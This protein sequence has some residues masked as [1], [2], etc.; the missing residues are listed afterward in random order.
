MATRLLLIDP[1][2]KF[3]VT[4][5]QALDG[6]GEFAVTVTANG[7][8]AL[9]AL[10][11]ERHDLVVMAF[12]TPDMDVLEILV[13]T[14]QVQ[15]RIPVIVTP[16][17]P[18]EQDRVRL[19][20]VQGAIQKPYS[21][22]NLIQYIRSVMAR[23]E[24][25]PTSPH[26]TPRP[27][28]AAP[29]RPQPTDEYSPPQMP[30]ALLH[31]LDDQ[32]KPPPPSPTEL[33]DRVEE[34]KLEPPP[35]PAPRY[36]D[37]DRLRTPAPAEILE[38][39]E[40]L[41]R[42]R[43]DELV[44]SWETPDAASEPEEDQAVED[45]GQTHR[46]TWEEPDATGE[47]GEE[48]E[49]A[50]TA[51]LFDWEEPDE[52]ATL[53][54]RGR[55]DEQP[56]VTREL[57][58]W[59][60]ADETGTLGERGQADEEQPVTR[61][62]YNWE[63]ADETA[64]LGE[65][66]TLNGE[67]APPGTTRALAWDEE[68]AETR[69]LSG[70]EARDDVMSAHGWEQKP[71]DTKPLGIREDEP[72]PR[73]DDTPTVPT[74]DLEGVR[75]FLAT[76]HHEQDPSVFGEV[77][78]AVAQAPPEP[79]ARS[80]DDRVFDDLV[81][82]MRGPDT[83]SPGRSTLEDLLASIATDTARG[84]SD[85]DL[86]PENTLD[87]VLD[88][89]RRGTSLSPA[90]D[91]TEDAL[92]ESE[93]DDATIGDVIGDLFDPAFEGVLAALAG[94]EIEDE[95]PEPSYTI[96][97]R[98]GRENLAPSEEDQIGFE[99]L[100]ADEDQP[101]WLE[102]YSGDEIEPA[103]PYRDERRE[104]AIQ[105]PPVTA[106]DSSS[107]PAT[108]ALSAVSSP[109][110]DDFSLND[111]LA[112]IEEQLPP[113]RTDRP[114]LKPLPSWERGR[115]SLEAKQLEAMFDHI[116][117]EEDESAAEGIAPPPHIAP[118]ED[119]PMPGL[120]TP[121]PIGKDSAEPTQPVRARRRD[122]EE[123][124]PPVAEDINGVPIQ[125]ADTVPIRVPVADV[126]DAAEAWDA[127][128][129]EL[130]E[131]EEALAAELD[132]LLD[133]ELA[134]AD[135]AEIAAI[136]EYEAGED[137][138]PAMLSVA[139]LMALADLPLDAESAEFDPLSEE[140]AAV[141]FDAYQA[142]RERAALLAGEDEAAVGDEF[143]LED[144]V[145]DEEYEAAEEVFMAGLR[146][147]LEADAEP[148]AVSEAEPE[149]E[150]AA[151]YEPDY[152]QAFEQAEEPAYEAAYEP[153]PEDAWD[154]AE[155]AEQQADEDFAIDERVI[156][157]D[158]HL[159]P[160][161]ADE[162]AWMLMGDEGEDYAAAEADDEAALARIAVE[163]TQY[164]LE[165]SAQATMLSRPGTLLAQAGDLPDSAMDRLFSTVD[166]A[167]RSSPPQTDSLIRYISL[168]DVGECL[169][170]SVLVEQDLA[171]SMIFNANTPVRAIRRQAR[172][173]SESLAFVPERTDEEPPAS[174][175][176]PSRPTDLRPPQ[177]LRTAVQVGQEGEEEVVEVEEAPRAD[178]PSIGYTCVWLPH[179]A[180]PGLND[181]LADELP[182]WLDAL[183]ANKVWNVHDVAVYEDYV[184]VSLE[185]PFKTL[186]DDVIVEM[187]DETTAR[188]AEQLPD[189]LS[190]S[191][192]LWSDGYYVV[193]PPRE[194]TEREIMSFVTYHTQS[195]VD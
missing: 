72:P 117:R 110:D 107:Y 58:D 74:H 183:A 163:L 78:D 34:E 121:P 142:E 147:S 86:P 49:P 113:A 102:S 119:L 8:A 83:S 88:A 126:D 129:D 12:N 179:S 95:I 20:D 61:E 181:D 145:T 84:M 192:L 52:T 30:A 143:D 21:A 15:H 105:E 184:T 11:R 100:S 33:L 153:E 98:G 36:E 185:V 5:K 166:N 152:A 55:V 140:W 164:S 54:E 159:I 174:K 76:D 31:L 42:S 9:D 85:D 82:S 59:E 44:A 26:A 25:R 4:I 47:L 120:I 68:P 172:R 144:Y 81:D 66:R 51:E 123:Q 124:L 135:T 195:Q 69:D 93:L 1:D 65:T 116:E 45:S 127:G 28:P 111:L 115:S 136:E 194:L 56:P 162:A 38:E 148:E 79:R 94:E 156:P 71:R 186:P 101:A 170:Y 167:W 60:E 139:E 157:D 109:D 151:D 40:A 23:S 67:P 160:V 22:R 112:Q 99:D 91:L 178:E 131:A 132:S 130:A 155:P 128:E 173:L 180:G 18:A 27:A 141:D 62:L 64:T 146:A 190:A 188:C 96:M 125:E 50:G 182:G 103:E 106:E 169:L 89:I 134:A 168:P 29:T 16:F 7:Q 90:P 97:P 57:Y 175:T 150:A 191:G 138:A 114:R 19:L 35:R 165:S 189:L 70:L 2:I 193:S 39:F 176:Q 92:A 43:I 53:G 13:Q 133:E 87:Y 24:Q 37:E 80:E 75:Q 149:I 158:E 17:S 3:A 122:E 73:E 104:P 137:E 10:R 177:G 63:E 187:M 154:A 48:E 77:L 108:A 32:E 171:L 6:T 14:R 118:P 46:L 41:E 161:P